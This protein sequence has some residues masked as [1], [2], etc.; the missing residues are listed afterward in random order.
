[1]T[2]AA[3]AQT[4]ASIGETEVGRPRLFTRVGGVVANVVVVVV[5]VAV[6]VSVCF[7]VFGVPLTACLV[8]G[9]AFAAFR[10]RGAIASLILSVAALSAPLEYVG[11]VQT[12]RAD[13]NA[14][15]IGV[16]DAAGVL[17]LNLG[18]AS[19]GRVAGFPEVVLLRPGSSARRGARQA[20]A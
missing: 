5:I 17:L 4:E 6:F 16:R 18:M 9:V 20:V 11:R 10:R 12:Q 2:G 15:R 3:D 13:L 8:A 14:G 1:M 7:F 19:G